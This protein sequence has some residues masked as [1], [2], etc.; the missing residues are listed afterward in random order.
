MAGMMYA[1]FKMLDFVKIKQVELFHE[2]EN[3]I[4]NKFEC[5]TIYYVRYALVVQRRK[6]TVCR[7]SYGGKVE[8]GARKNIEMT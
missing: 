6:F 4:K 7:I 1:G 2:L 3:K 8:R 5:L